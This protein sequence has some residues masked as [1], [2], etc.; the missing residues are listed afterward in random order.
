M[1]FLSRSWG[2]VTGSCCVAP[3]SCRKS[4][5]DMTGYSCTPCRTVATR[6]TVSGCLT[7]D[8]MCNC[9]TV[10]RDAITIAIWSGVHPDTPLA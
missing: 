2:R 3:V 5:A 9:N 10:T 8:R 6:T 4:F 7:Q 1:H